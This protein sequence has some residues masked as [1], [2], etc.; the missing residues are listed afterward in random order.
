MAEGADRRGSIRI[1]YLSTDQVYPGDR[2]VCR[3]GG[4]GSRSTHADVDPSRLPIP[5][6]A[7]G[8]SKLAFEN[9]L[10]ERRGRTC[11]DDVK[12]NGLCTVILRASNMIGPRSSTTGQ[13]KFIQW[14]DSAL[15]ASL[16]KTFEEDKQ[17]SS[18]RLFVDEIRSF[19]YVRDVARFVLAA[20]VAEKL[21]DD[22]KS[23]VAVYNLGGL[24]AL[25]RADLGHRVC[26]VRGILKDVASQIISLEKRADVVGGAYPSPLD[27]GMDSS[28]ILQDFGNTMKI[29]T[30]ED[31]LKESLD[32]S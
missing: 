4:K 10:A 22:G 6:N 27:I 20:A 24:E 11:Y 5:I 8:R 28:K 26:E 25:S 1:I 18:V 31:A 16:A 7:Y 9:L 29:T 2:T 12:I 13:G 19:V 14:L 21:P 23:E 30:L 17:S 15:S 32:N 3:A